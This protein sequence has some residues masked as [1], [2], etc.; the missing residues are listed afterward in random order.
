MPDPKRRLLILGGGGFA[1]EIAEIAEQLPGCVIAGFVQDLWP[2]RIGQRLEGFPYYYIEEVRPLAGDHV[3]VCGCGS[4]NR[5]GFIRRAEE[6]GL[7]FSTLVHPSAVV[8][9]RCRIGDGAVVAAGAV[10]GARVVLGRHVFVGR[11]SSIGH[12]TM[13]EDHVFVGPGATIAGACK[14]GRA[15]LIGAGAVIRDHLT[16]GTGST[17]GAGAAA[18]KDVAPGALLAA[19]RSILLE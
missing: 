11:N 9:P 15:A 5:I 7:R 2:E 6:M 3:A 8:S 17:V 12:D 14:I 4:G 19:P 1:L 10:V 18:L 16:I 13:V